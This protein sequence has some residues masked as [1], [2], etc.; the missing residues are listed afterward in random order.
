[1]TYQTQILGDPGEACKKAECVDCGSCTAA[2]ATINNNLETM[3]I[4]P[5]SVRILKPFGALLKRVLEK[6]KEKD[7]PLFWNLKTA[8][9]NCC[10]PPKIRGE[11]KVGKLSNH[12][13]GCAIDLYYGPTIDDQGDDKAQEGLFRLSK[14]MN[15]ESIYWGAGFDT[16]DA[17]HFEPSRQL[18]HTWACDAAAYGLTGITRPSDC[19]ATTAALDGA[20]DGTTVAATE[21]TSADA[22]GDVAVAED[23]PH[24]DMDGFLANAD[25]GYTVESGAVGL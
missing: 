11:V 25:A 24:S 2:A 8:G 3:D 10:R 22:G 21:E 13:W 14:Y 6:V 18:L 19:D 5:F 16:E 17:M 4:G 15:N 9:A 1:M 12:A 20:G 7:P 23:A